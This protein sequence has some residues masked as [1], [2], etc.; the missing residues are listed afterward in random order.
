MAETAFSVD[1]APG[2][3]ASAARCQA[4]AAFGRALRSPRELAEALAHLED[5]PHRLPYPLAPPTWPP[6]P[7]PDELQRRYTDLFEAAG[8]RSLVSLH[9]SD[10]S[11]IAQRRIWEDLIRFYEH[12]GLQYDGGAIRLWPDHLLI[13]LECVH[14]LAFLESGTAADPASLRRA[15]RDFLER[16]LLSWLPRL[17][18]RLGS[19]PSA[20]PYVTLTSVLQQFLSADRDWLNANFQPAS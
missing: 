1:V 10:F 3:A 7:A 14:Y 4:Y 6:L 16:H 18:Q 15:Q 17:V 5:A 19:L 13:E 12:F 9:E 2:R 8:R 20:E 11:E